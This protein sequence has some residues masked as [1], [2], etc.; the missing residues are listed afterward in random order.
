MRER[1]DINSEFVGGILNMVYITNE[2]LVTVIDVHTG[3]DNII[4]ARVKTGAGSVGYVKNT[5]VYPLQRSGR[6]RRSK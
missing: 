5:F 4:W 6:G 1:P 2:D 3:A